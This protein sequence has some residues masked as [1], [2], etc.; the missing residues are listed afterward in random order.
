[1]SQKKCTLYVLSFHIPLILDVRR[2]DAHQ[3]GLYRR[4]VTQDFS[5][6]PS[7]VHAFIFIVRR[8]QPSLTLVDLEVEFFVPTS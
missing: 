2:V 5:I 7:A 6:F 1:M 3:P 4:K 8:I